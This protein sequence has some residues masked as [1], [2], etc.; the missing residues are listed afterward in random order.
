MGTA[1]VID[2]LALPRARVRRS[3]EGIGEPECAGDEEEDAPW[4]ADQGYGCICNLAMLL[5]FAVEV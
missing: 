5:L 2:D 4:R 1:A 3:V